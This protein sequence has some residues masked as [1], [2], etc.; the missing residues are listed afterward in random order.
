MDDVLTDTMSIQPA[1]S[2]FATI[3]AWEPIFAPILFTFFSFFTRFY[4]IGR[5]DIVTWDEAQY[6]TPSIG[7]LGACLGC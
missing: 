4:Q 3:D 6:D 2:I 1:K 5:S 7:E